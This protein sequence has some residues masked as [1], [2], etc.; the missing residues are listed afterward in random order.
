MEHAMTTTSANRGQVHSGSADNIYATDAFP[1]RVTLMQR[2]RVTLVRLSRPEKRNAIDGKM[3]EAIRSVFN[4]LP[5]ETC[6]VV[7][8]GEGDHFCAGADLGELAK[9]SGLDLGRFSRNMH[10]VLDRIEYGAVPVIAALHGGVIGG[11][12]ELAAAAH[13][14]IAERNTYYALPEGMRGIFVGGGG[15]V[16]IPRL[17]GTSR[18]VDMMLTGRTYSAE[19]DALGLSQY[20]VENG[21]GVAAAVKLAEQIAKNTSVSNFAAIQ[22]LPRIARADSEAG[23]LMES[24]MA[25]IA[26]SDGEAKTRLR[27]FLDKRA[28][29]ALHR[30]VAGE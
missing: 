21:N 24:L 9:H 26:L 27:D 29:K 11:G 30:S 22:A 18:M 23:F 14:R 13:I 19:Q 3:L 5:K 6:A 7:L 1:D 10:E 25:T 2:G 16:R 12:L 4:D 17:I 8:H 20:V 15:A 28:A